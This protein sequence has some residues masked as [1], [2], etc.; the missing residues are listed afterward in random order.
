MVNLTPCIER[1]SKGYLV[2]VREFVTKAEHEQETD[3]DRL[4]YAASKVA[5]AIPA[6][7]GMRH[8]CVHLDVCMRAI[9]LI[10][11]DEPE[12]VVATELARIAQELPRI[13][14]RYDTVLTAG[15]AE[16]KRG[17]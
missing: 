9:A 3:E 6:A 11:A 8:T 10:L 2:Q 15:L 1:D 13:V 7:L 17:N 12:P 4:L 5:S 16:R 14:A